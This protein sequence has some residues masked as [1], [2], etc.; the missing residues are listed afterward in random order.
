MSG[1]KTGAPV[2][3]HPG[4]SSSGPPSITGWCCRGRTRSRQL[5][6]CRAPGRCRLLVGAT[7]ASGLRLHFRVFRFLPLPL[8][9]ER[10][11]YHP[12]PQS[13]YMGKLTPK[14]RLHRLPLRLTAAHLCIPPYP[15][16]PIYTV[17][18]RLT[19]RIPLID[20]RLMAYWTL[21]AFGRPIPDARQW[22]AA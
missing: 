17:F 18:H 11:I 21:L 6:F 5:R 12:V 16:S 3:D 15:L 19:R 7:H 8:I 2:P 10:G 22:F 14:K 20:M 1:M 9:Y 13:F 4:F